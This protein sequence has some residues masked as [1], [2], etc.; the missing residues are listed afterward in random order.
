MNV[1]KAM[2]KDIAKQKANEFVKDFEKNIDKNA[3]EI[4]ESIVPLEIDA[5]I[6]KPAIEKIETI[7]KKEWETKKEPYI[8]MQEKNLAEG[9]PK[10][11][12]RNDII[13][14]D[15]VI[16]SNAKVGDSIEVFDIAGNKYKTKITAISP[17]GTS[18]KV[19]NKNVLKVWKELSYTITGETL[20]NKKEFMEN[21]NGITLDSPARVAL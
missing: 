4:A 17:E 12:V 14:T 13:E 20:S 7:I 18:F 8:E 19:L 2:P 11:E 6:R 5:S 1:I 15:T 3:K 21:I 9:K 10:F 16:N